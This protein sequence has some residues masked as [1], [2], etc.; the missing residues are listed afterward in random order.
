MKKKLMVLALAALLLC[1]CLTVGV[2]AAEDVIV[3][4]EENGYELNVKINLI[5][6]VS[7][8]GKLNS[9][10][11]KLVYNH[12]N[13]VKGITDEYLMDVADVNNDGKI[14]SVDKKLIY[15]HI[16]GVKSLW[17]D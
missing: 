9:V 13:A 16:N 3:L 12:I 4:N 5:G 15:N 1:G 6:D 11:K 14:N 17:T 8:D 10:D 7:G 2:L